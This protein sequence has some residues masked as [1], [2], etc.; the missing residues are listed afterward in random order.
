MI[1]VGN[2]MIEHYASLKAVI[3]NSFLTWQF[4]IPG[5]GGKQVQMGRFQ[6]MIPITRP[7]WLWLVRNESS[8]DFVPY[9]IYWNIW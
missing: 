9:L 1:N 4:V 3:V 7:G 8:H 5:V 2:Q 6:H